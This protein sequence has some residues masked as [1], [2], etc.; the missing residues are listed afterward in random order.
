M[1]D[2]S[3]KWVESAES[4]IDWSLDF[5][6]ARYNIRGSYKDRMTHRISISMA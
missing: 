1:N 3:F 5:P 2:V 6:K 4:H